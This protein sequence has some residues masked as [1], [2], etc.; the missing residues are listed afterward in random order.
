M[1]IIVFTGTGG[2]GVS[3]LAAAAAA[4]IAGGGSRTL[5]YGLGPGLAAAFDRAL[6]VRPEPLAADLWALEAAPGRHDAPGPV[7]TWLRDLF[8]WR[9]MD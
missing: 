4:A 9:D 6:G 5:A 2:A 1:R 8:A 7:L 3:T